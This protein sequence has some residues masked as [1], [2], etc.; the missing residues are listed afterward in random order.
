MSG[1]ISRPY[2]ATSPPIASSAP[3]AIV[4]MPQPR[5]Q[6]GRIVYP[7]M[8]PY[9]EG[10]V[11]QTADL[12]TIDG[13]QGEGG[14]QILRSAASLSAI[15]GKPVRITNI[16]KNRAK[17]GLRPQHRMALLAAA[18]VCGG[19]GAGGFGRRDRHHVLARRPQGPARRII[20][21]RHR[22]RRQHRARL[23]DRAADPAAQRQAEPGHRAWRDAQSACAA[24]PLFAIC[25][26]IGA[27]SH[28]VRRRLRDAPPRLLPGRVAASW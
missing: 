22:H 1:V 23:S 6:H 8:G 12:I 24:V 17:P 18:Q 2:P 13:S 21:V 27:A 20:R 25:I 28:G 3:T 19:G 4:T 26:S 14:G 16:R 7:P 15:S 11:S 9:A 5:I 10:V